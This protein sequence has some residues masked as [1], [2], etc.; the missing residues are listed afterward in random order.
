MF[1]INHVKCKFK[2]LSVST[3][4]LFNVRKSPKEGSFFAFFLSKMGP[5]WGVPFNVRNSPKEGSLLQFFNQNGPHVGLARPVGPTPWPC[6]T[7]LFHWFS[8]LLFF[9]FFPYFLAFLLSLLFPFKD[10]IH[11]WIR[12]FKLPKNK[13]TLLSLQLIVLHLGCLTL[14]FVPKVSH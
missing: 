2:D 5:M 8:F 3:M 6:N 4:D 10:G 1:W 9:I 13:E 7:W 12:I 14:G 11:F